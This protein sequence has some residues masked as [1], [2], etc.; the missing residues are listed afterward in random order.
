MAATLMGALVMIA[1]V[2]FPVL[3]A[4]GLGPVLPVALGAQVAAGLVVHVLL[5]TI[6]YRLRPVAPGA[7]PE[8]A[9]QHS[10]AQY[11]Q[12]MILRFALSEA[13]AILSLAAAFVVGAYTV[14]LGGMVVSLV[15][16]ALHVWPGER[17][18]GKSITALERS[19]GRSNLRQ[20]L[21]LPDG[22]F[23]PG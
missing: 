8:A 14:Y 11:Q 7:A 13:I 3:A 4:D 23:L 9:E 20:R 15:L 6:G 5:E 16:L 18:V 12:W 19:G 10:V 22:P 2:T 1:V 17:T 21:G